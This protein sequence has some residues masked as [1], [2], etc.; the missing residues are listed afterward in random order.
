LGNGENHESLWRRCLGGIWDGE[1]RSGRRRR[2]A[3]HKD[4][5][6]SAAKLL[7]QRLGLSRLDRCGLSA[8]LRGLHPL[9]DARRG[10][11][12]QYQWR[13]LEPGVRQRH[14]GAHQQA[15][16]RLEVAL[17][18]EQHQPVGHRH[19]DVGTDRLWLVI[20]RHAGSGLRPDF[21]LAR[22]LATLASHEQRQG[23]D[24]AERQRRFESRRPVGQF[25]VLHRRQQQDVGHPDLRPRQLVGAGR[26]HRLRSVGRGLRFLAVRIH[27]RLRRFQRHRA[28]P[29]EYGVQVSRRLRQFP[30]RGH[31]S[32]RR[33]QPGE[34]LR[35][36]VAGPARRRRSEPV[37][38]HIVGRRNRQLRQGRREHQH[39]Q[40]HMRRFE[41]GPVHRAD[42]MHRR[43]S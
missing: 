26:P 11:H 1:F 14:P 40:R 9:C 5:G 3:N 28:R 31:R 27:R 7:R 39:L 10:P 41:I 43:H 2:P 34:R 20:G 38:R 25:A 35:F 15:E 4:R 16:L 33:L 30:R 13:C 8:D 17:V 6:A 36:D 24:L 18:A 22:Q 23:A 19:Q 37:R 21:R 29:F 12:V 42:G 32:G